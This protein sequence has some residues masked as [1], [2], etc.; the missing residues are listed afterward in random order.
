MDTL[1]NS[2]D[3]DESLQNAKSLQGLQWLQ[4]KNKSSF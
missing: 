1:A 3:L 4:D 2:G